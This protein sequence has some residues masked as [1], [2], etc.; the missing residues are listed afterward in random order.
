MRDDSR[1]RW[2]GGLAAGHDTVKEAAMKNA[3]TRRPDGG[4]AMTHK[5]KEG[6]AQDQPTGSKPCRPGA[7]F[8]AGTAR[9]GR[10]SAKPEMGKL[11][12]NGPAIR[13]PGPVRAGRGSALST[14]A[15]PTHARRPQFGLG[16][17][18]TVGLR[19]SDNGRWAWSARRSGGAPGGSSE[20]RRV[21][22]QPCLRGKPPLGSQWRETRSGVASRCRDTSTD[23]R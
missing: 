5:D 7:A 3:A 22:F 6:P 17:G 23:T 16:T 2:R 15:C 12:R 10:Q 14:P 19:F 11:K 20:A 1:R 13:W 9:R 8:G 4:P 18:G 21:A